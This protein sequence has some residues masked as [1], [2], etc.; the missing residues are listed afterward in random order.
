VQQHSNTTG[1]QV[2]QRNWDCKVRERTSPVQM[3]AMHAE[4]YHAIC[5]RSWQPVRATRV[6]P[7][8]SDIIPL[9]MSTTMV[10]DCPPPPSQNDVLPALRCNAA[11]AVIAPHCCLPPRPLGKPYRVPGLFA[12]TSGQLDDCHRR[13]GKPASDVDCLDR[14]VAAAWHTTRAAAAAWHTTRAA[15]ARDALCMR[16]ISSVS[17]EERQITQ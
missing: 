3:A 4:V 8:K 13:R 10:L 7:T 11:K 14:A 2:Q 1:R 5:L 12:Q 6:P 15:A 16:R 9:P 17:T